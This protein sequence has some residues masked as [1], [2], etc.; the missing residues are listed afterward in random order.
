MQKRTSQTSAAARDS[1]SE[2]VEA[3]YA[4]F[5][6]CRVGATVEGCPCCVSPT[7]ARALA[8][9]PLRAVPGDLLDRY[10]FKAVTTWG[11]EADLRH[12]VPAIWERMVLHRLG[13]DPQIVYGK[14]ARMILPER[15]REALARVTYDWLGL[16]L[17]DAREPETVVEC[18]GI[19]GLSMAPIL[20]LL[21][22]ASG[23]PVI[24]GIA[25]LAIALGSREGYSWSFWKSDREQ[26]VAT[27][28]RANA[29]ARLEAAFFAHPD[30]PEAAEW[31]YAVDLLS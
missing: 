24:H 16:A 23:P 25:S 5:A 15:Q 21:D 27:W 6:E 14:V 29:R 10:A 19:F 31:S 1:L 3:L 30:A 18:A 2:S 7:E 4:A 22:A 28:M 12:F 20:A 8:T 9:S 17:V 13:V 11:T 26:A